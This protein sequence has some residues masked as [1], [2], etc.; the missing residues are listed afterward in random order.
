VG[1]IGWCWSEW[2]K[3]E[4]RTKNAFAKASA[5]REGKVELR[6][7]Y[8]QNPSHKMIN[9]NLAARLMGCCFAL[10]LTSCWTPNQTAAPA[11]SALEKF[12]EAHGRYPTNFVELAPSARDVGLISSSRKPTRSPHAE[13]AAEQWGPSNYESLWYEVHGDSYLLTVK[14]AGWYMHI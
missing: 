14:H 12:H 11:I 13:A 5:R 6:M 3:E 8:W 2:G 7:H 1:F 4:G 10:C 9:R